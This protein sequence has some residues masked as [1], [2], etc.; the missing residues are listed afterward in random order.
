MQDKTSGNW[1]ARM[2]NK[3]RFAMDRRCGD[4]R[5]KVYLLGYFMKGGVERRSGKERRFLGERRVDW[6]RATEWSSVPGTGMNT[7]CGDSLSEYA[8]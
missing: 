7:V 3:N 1:R 5:C 4:N 8:T 6:V 2:P